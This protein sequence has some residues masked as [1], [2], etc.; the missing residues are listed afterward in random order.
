MEKT[1]K[2][3]P[4]EFKKNVLSYLTVKNLNVKTRFFK[5]SPYEKKRYK[6]EFVGAELW[7]YNG[8]SP[9]GFLITE[10]SWFES[11]E[12]TKQAFIDAFKN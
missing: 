7:L 1:F 8:K 4:E 2:S 9:V 3:N 12:E 10:T 6:P 11:D 5:V